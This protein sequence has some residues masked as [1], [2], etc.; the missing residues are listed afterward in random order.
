MTINFKKEIFLR[1]IICLNIFLLNPLSLLA[2]SEGKFFISEDGTYAIDCF[3]GSYKYLLDDSGLEKDKWYSKA[4]MLKILSSTISNTYKELDKKQVDDIAKETYS[5]IIKKSEDYCMQDAADFQKRGNYKYQEKDFT[6]AINDYEKAIKIDNKN[7]LTHF[8]KALAQEDIG[9]IDKAINSYN[10][11]IK[12]NPNYS[13]AYT[14]RGILKFQKKNYEGA[15]SD[16]NKSIGL[17]EYFKAFNNRGLVKSKLGDKKGAV[18]DFK[19]AIKL[20]PNNYN[21]YLNLG[22]ILLND[23]EKYEEAL[24]NYEIALKLNPLES[25]KWLIYI[26]MGKTKKLQG[27]FRESE[28]YYKESIK[29]KPENFIGYFTLGNLY[30]KEQDFTKAINAFNKA[31]ELNPNIEFVINSLKKSYYERGVFKAQKKQYSFAVDDFDK[32]IKIDSLYADAIV[33]RAA[34]YLMLKNADRYCN[35]INKA[36]SLNNIKAKTIYSEVE[37]LG[38]SCTN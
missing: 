17:E 34:A 4:Q 12:L 37:K 27:K 11:S 25:D 8:K 20:E 26:Q 35:D 31:N 19:K 3:K 21:I 1:G 24:V 15:L 9:E 5:E 36:I 23:L 2:E 10:I 16:L 7:F 38:F 33:D 6:G 18:D 28:D 22:D 14:N 13:N 30:L 32:A 29:L